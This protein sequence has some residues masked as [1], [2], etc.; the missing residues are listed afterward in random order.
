MCPN[1]DRP[2][3]PNSQQPDDDQL[4]LTQ[5]LPSSDP[6]QAPRAPQEPSPRSESGPDDD[7]LDRTMVESEPVDETISEQATRLND[8]SAEA[9]APAE[10][11]ETISEQATRADRNDDATLADDPEDRTLLESEVGHDS[12]L[13]NQTKADTRAQT[14]DL[15]KPTAVGDQTAPTHAEPTARR[16]R[17]D[18]DLVGTTLGGCELTSLLGKGAM[19]AVY[20]AKQLSLQRTVAVKTIRPEYCEEENFLKRFRQE[21]LVVGRFNT[22][23]VV[24]IYDVGLEEGFHYILMEYVASGSLLDRLKRLPDRR[25][26]VPMA[27]KWL[28]QSAEGLLEAERLG[29]VHRDIKPANLLIDD[30]DRVK[31]AD[32]GIAKSLESSIE[33]TQSEGIL[34][35]PLYMSPE[36]CEGRRQLDARSDMYSLGATFYQALTGKPPFQADSVFAIL[37]QKTTVDFLSPRQALDLNVEDVPEP[38]NAV[39]ERMTQKDPELRYASFND[40]IDDLEAIERGLAPKPMPKPKPDKKSPLGAIV[41]VI[42]LLVVSAGGY[43]AYTQMNQSSDDPGDGK[44]I[45]EQDPKNGGNTEI[46][47]AGLTGKIGETEDRPVDIDPPKQNDPP[48]VKNDPPRG[49]SSTF[50]WAGFQSQVAGLTSSFASQGP[51]GTLDQD[52]S[53]LRSRVANLTPPDDYASAQDELN[54]LIDSIQPARQLESAEILGAT[55]VYRR[56]ALDFP[57]ATLGEYWEKVRQPFEKLRGDGG[58]AWLSTWIDKSLQQQRSQLSADLISVLNDRRESL[59]RMRSDF[60]SWKLPL[61]DWKAE[62][63]QWDAART[64]IRGFLTE[65]AFAAEKPSGDDLTAWRDQIASRE[66]ILAAVAQFEGSL[67]SL[68]SEAEEKLTSADVLW[69]S[70]SD[71]EKLQESALSLRGTLMAA[72]LADAQLPGEVFLPEARLDRLKEIESTA[73]TWSERRRLVQEALEALAK[74]DAASARERLSDRSL[75]TVRDKSPIAGLITSQQAVAEGFEL[76][77]TKLDIEAAK[78]QLEQARRELDASADVLMSAG[79]EPFAELAR[80]AA[81]YPERCLERL[82]ELESRTKSAMAP[83]LGGQAEPKGESASVEPFF[84]DRYEVSVER[85]EAFLKWMKEHPEEALKLFDGNQENFRD[86]SRGPDYLRS[87]PRP[88]PTG[89]MQSVNYFEALAFVR[90]EQKSLP[91]AAEW[92]VA[93]KGDAS[94]GRVRRYAFDP[95]PNAR[96]IGRSFDV[97]F[98]NNKKPMAVDSGEEAAGFTGRNRVHHLAGNVAEWL[99][100]D[101]SSNEARLAGAAYSDSEAR[102]ER[103]TGED[104]YIDRKRTGNAKYGFRGILRPKDFFG[105]LVPKK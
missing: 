19:G 71:I 17:R 85:Y 99:H 31:I 15:D 37:Q 100:A 92:W 60:E 68:Q 64:A 52:A 53:A 91:T 8:R 32:F 66:K 97:S 59:E 57:F 86:A 65:E 51:R 104:F 14:P 81:S 58:V 2:L 101:P 5:Q 39:I 29:V 46:G 80:Q 10:A 49:G 30:N 82:T 40:L 18:E 72:P 89:P 94:Q 61:A 28:K 98:G 42:A 1:D 50:D 38:L 11:D 47:H 93:A 20:Q 3:D 87:S 45:G 25:L 105:E 33:L 12:V 22:P 23:Y 55:N 79:D 48:V 78:K 84:L 35:T 76:L 24:Q 7:E 67:E 73:K 4:D 70:P 54:I 63:A 103:L 83:C 41:A 36:Q 90:H 102:E 74:R 21:A 88:Y 75:N 77:L 95:D 27:I 34:G 9:S 43:Y 56:D 26:E 16:P 13:E 62:L 44:V 96:D 6:K 69:P